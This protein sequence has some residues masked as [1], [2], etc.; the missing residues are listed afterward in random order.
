MALKFCSL[1][2]IGYNDSFDPTCPQCMIAHI[3]PPEQL[4]VDTNEASAGYG[5][6]IKAGGAEGDRTLRKVR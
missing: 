1:H 2:Q 6:P 3:P 5:Y 4:L